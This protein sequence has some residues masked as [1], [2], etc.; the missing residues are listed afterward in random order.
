MNPE[1]V[2]R[3]IYLDFEKQI[4]DEKPAIA[5]VLVDDDYTCYGLDPII[6]EAVT[7]LQSSRDNEQWE[8]Q[9]V[10]TFALSILERAEQEGRKIIGYTMTERNLLVELIGE[11]ERIDNVYFD[12][13]IAPWFRE[14][15]RRT[16]RRLRRENRND[17]RWR[18]NSSVGLKDFLSLGW[19]G[20]TYPSDLRNYS[21]ATAL[22]RMR[23]ELQRRGNYQAVARSVKRKFTMIHRYNFHDCKGMK[24]L[25]EFRLSRESS[26]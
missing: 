16:Y 21:P 26:R 8:F 3:G 23:T 15:Y 11:E 12:A 10:N 22:G 14:R 4:D 2:N 9:D 18:T 17:A 5:G 1:I 25:L 6:E 24:H 13:N 20:Y 7:I 19:V